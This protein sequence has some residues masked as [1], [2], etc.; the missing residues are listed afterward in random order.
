MSDEK[1]IFMKN[2]SGPE[3]L[4]VGCQRSGT[5]WVA[6]LLNNHPEVACFPAIAF[7]KESGEYS[8]DFGEIHLFNTL[9]SLEPGNE[10]K[11]VRPISNYL[12]THHKYFAD[13]VLYEGK[14]SKK[15]LYDKFIQRYNE[16]C[17]S[18]RGTKKLVGESTPAYIFHLDFIDSFYPGIKKLCIMRDPKD[19]IISWH[20]NNIRKG[21]KAE[22][23]ISDEFILDYCQKRITKEYGSLLAYK[24]K[25]HC[26]TYERLTNN[27]KEVISG[28]LKYLEVRIDEELIGDMINNASF[29]KLTAIDSGAVGRARGEESIKSHYRKGIIGDWNNHLTVEQAKLVDNMCINLR[30]KV[31]NKYKLKKE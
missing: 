1:Y 11:P 15:E 7:R 31:F 16:L 20:Y 6:A 22:M 9:A 5:S 21:R 23:T 17:D 28:I 27:A 8:N 14:V 12:T 2:K 10:D 18:K 24:G 26:F 25:V 19:K 3:F 13:L 30:T 4:I 29:Q